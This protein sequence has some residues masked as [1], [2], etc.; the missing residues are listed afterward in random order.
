MRDKSRRR[1]FFKGSGF[2]IAVCCCVLAIGIIGYFGTQPD[3]SGDIAAVSSPTPMRTPVP[4]AQPIAIATPASVPTEPPI[5]LVETPAPIAETVEEV[6]EYEPVIDEAEIY[7]EPVAGDNVV[8]LVLPVEGDVACHY[9]D[10]LVYNEYLGDWRAHNGVDLKAEV[11]ADVVCAA[12]GVVESITCDYLGTTVTID[13][14]NCYKTR[15]ANFSPKECL[16]VGSEVGYGTVIATVAEDA[17]EN[18]TEAH[19]HFEMLVDGRYVNPLD[20]VN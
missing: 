4:T 19:I 16:K 3:E 13:H 5:E 9:T 11:G 6:E 20:Y 15:Y 10:A 1:S 7:A 17:K 12:A 18:T 2:Y 8:Q 14:Q